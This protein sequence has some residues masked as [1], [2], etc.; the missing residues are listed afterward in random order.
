MKR[1]ACSSP[2]GFVQA[3]HFSP[4]L[5]VAYIGSVV[6]PSYLYEYL[7][8]MRLFKFGFSLL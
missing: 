5:G 6:G 2:S 1:D 8:N 3:A 7:I 4:V